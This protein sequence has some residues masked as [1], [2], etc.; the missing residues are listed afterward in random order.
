MR[1]LMSQ[2]PRPLN[3]DL[4][5]AVCQMI[6]LKKLKKFMTIVQATSSMAAVF[7]CRP[8]S[9]RRGISSTIVRPA[10]VARIP[11]DKRNWGMALRGGEAK[12]IAAERSSR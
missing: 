12:L 6:G 2:Y 4:V 3:A 10:N 9:I 1:M 7:W 11:A 5:L 8:W